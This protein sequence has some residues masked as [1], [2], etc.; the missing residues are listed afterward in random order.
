[1]DKKPFLSLYIPIYNR[2]DYLER[3]LDRFLEDKDLFEDVI[4]LTI[5]DNCSE[6]DLLSCCKKYQ[7]K[8]L[9]VRY[10]RNK[11]NLGSNGNFEWC[12]KDSKGEYTWLL[13]S[14]DIP[15]PGV[16]RKVVSILKE[17]DFGLL[18]IRGNQ[19]EI[20]L[21]PFESSEKMLTKLSHWVTF[22]SSNIYRTGYTENVTIEKYKETWLIQVPIYIT[23]CINSRMNGYLKYNDLFESN[24]DSLSGYNLY[25]VF[26][27]NFLGIYDEFRRNKQISKRGYNNVKRVLFEYFLAPLT[28]RYKVFNE[29]TNLYLEGGWSILFEYYKTNWYTYVYLPL[30][31]VWF[32]IKKIK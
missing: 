9:N 1:M 26:V 2:I 28:I 31:F 19:G 27:R 4:Q 13:G 20:S 11:E 32:L 8:G 23:A 15:M 18:H 14:D 6:E 24:R 7:E 29:N 17:N 10:H 30:W 3:Q 12:I 16:L 25:T 21:V 22:M 5:S